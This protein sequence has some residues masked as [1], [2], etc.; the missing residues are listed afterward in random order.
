M[1]KSGGGEGGTPA[2]IEGGYVV[3]RAVITLLLVTAGLHW[4]G[5]LSLVDVPRP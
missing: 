5:T 2:G 1:L 3:R 4:A